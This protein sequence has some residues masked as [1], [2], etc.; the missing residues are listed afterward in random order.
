MTPKL[1]YFKFGTLLGLALTTTACGGTETA[2]KKSQEFGEMASSFST[3]TKLLSEDLYDSCVRRITY[4]TIRN[5]NSNRDLALA[6]CQRLNRPAVEESKIANAV[7]SDYAVYVGKLAAD[8]VVQFDGQFNAV[9]RALTD[10]SI[11]LANGPITL[12]STAVNTGTQI[13]NFVFRWA[14]DRYRKGTLRSA[15]VC[16]DTP[17]QSYTSGL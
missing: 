13:A 3:N 8:D 17:F 5:G 9:K 14:A 4:I 15:I 12:P 7:V 2:L 10:F 6:S 16:A 11:P 1:N